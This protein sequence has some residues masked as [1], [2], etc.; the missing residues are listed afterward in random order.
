[1]LTNLY[2]DIKVSKGTFDAKTGIWTIGDMEKGEIQTLTYSVKVKESWNA[3]ITDK[4]I[5]NKAIVTAGTEQKTEVTS[6]KVF[7]NNLNITKSTVDGTYGTSKGIHI[8]ETGTCV[9]Y[10][11]TVNASNINQDDA[12]GVKVTDIFSDN[13]DDI[14]R[15]YAI[16]G[17]ATTDSEEP[18]V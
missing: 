6:N 18:G 1:M 15:Y 4:T 8:D 16:E 9:K 3:A 17:A 5:S 11:I 12:S 10:T 7:N 2:K 14:E 13:K